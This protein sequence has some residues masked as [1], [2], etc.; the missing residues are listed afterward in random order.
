VLGDVLQPGL[1]VRRADQHRVAEGGQQL[2]VPGVVAADLDA[3]HVVDLRQP[4][5][6]PGGQRHPG[7][8]GVEQP[9]ADVH[10][11]AHVREPP[12]QALVGGGGVVGVDHHGEVRADRGRVPGQLD[13]LLGAVLPGVGEHRAPAPGPLHH[14]LGQLPPLRA[15]QRPELAHHPAAE[16][17]A[18]AQAAGEP[19][20]VRAQRGLVEQAGR[21]ERGGGGRPQAGEAVA[22]R[23]LGVRLRVVHGRPPATASRRASRP[24]AAWPGTKGCSGCAPRPGRPRW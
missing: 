13:G 8:A 6:E 10:A 2:Q 4:A 7:V 12:V 16:D 15:G 11:G 18:D 3:D 19:V 21:V 20:Q 23:L 17:P 24:P 14:D 5:D 9:D 22:G 1:L